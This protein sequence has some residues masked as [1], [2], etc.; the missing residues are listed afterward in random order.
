MSE[1]EMNLVFEL[2]DD[3][4]IT[5]KLVRATAL[6]G[7]RRSVLAYQSRSEMKQDEPDEA[8][9]ILRTVTYPDLIAPVV[10]QT[11]F[12]QWPISFEDFCDLP[13]DLVVVWERAVYALNPH[14]NT[15]PEAQVDAEKKV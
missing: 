10:E 2:D 3:R 9:R 5:L 1:N 4:T 13:D 6:I 12:D 7:M 15:L 8:V 14:W 11:G